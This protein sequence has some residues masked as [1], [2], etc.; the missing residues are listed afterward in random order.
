MA[1]DKDIKTVAKEFIEG[2]REALFEDEIAEVVKRNETEEYEGCCATHD[3]VDANAVMEE[4]VKKAGLHMFTD[5]SSID[6][7]W[8][9]NIDL[10]NKAWYMAKAVVFDIK[11]IDA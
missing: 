3:Y 10:V 5:F 9:D 7:K 11:K 1:S 2:I 6:P 4:A 8:E